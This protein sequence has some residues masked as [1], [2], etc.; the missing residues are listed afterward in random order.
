MTYPNTHLPA[1]QENT[2]GFHTENPGKRLQ[3]ARDCRSFQK[4]CD[5]SIRQA[6]AEDVGSGDIT[7]DA[8]FN[9]THIACAQLIAKDDGIVAGLPVFLRV[10]SLI[11][12]QPMDLHALR[13][14]GQPVRAGQVLARITGP[15][16]DILTAERVALNLLQRASG[17]ASMTHRFVTAARKAGN[18]NFRI[19]DTRKTVPGLRWLD[20]YAVLA[21][22]GDN[23]R[24]GLYDM[25]L[26]KENHIQAA[27]GITAAINRVRAY[28]QS[29][30]LNTA[31]EIEVSTLDELQETLP[32]R[33]D[34]ILLD[35]MDNAT[36]AEAVRITAGAI[37]L[38]ASGNVTE[39]LI[40]ELA[41][42]GVD[43]VSVGALTHSPKAL[44]MSLLIT[45]E[46]A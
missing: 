30:G 15:V 20:K 1:S 5:Q 44:D 26:I 18:H 10:F 43:C 31:I 27:G 23:H 34:R 38:E 9:P 19:L 35:N 42:I 46:S 25:A 22:G 4:H 2:P 28:Q 17:I 29:Q 7:T 11:A 32:L 12:D 13:E 36:L 3:K 16:K 39:E 41:R 40:P 21:G 6:L 37:P 33:P 24:F 14:D 8:I 45:P